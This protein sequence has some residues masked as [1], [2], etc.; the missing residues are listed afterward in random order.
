MKSYINQM[1]QLFEAIDRFKDDELKSACKL[2]FET[3]MM[4][5]F[6]NGELATDLNR[7]YLHKIKLENIKTLIK[8]QYAHKGFWQ[9]LNADWG[10][11][12]CDMHKLQWA[13]SNYNSE[14]QWKK[15]HMD[16]L[17]RCSLCIKEDDNYY[18]MYKLSIGIEGIF[19][20]DLYLPYLLGKDFF[21]KCKKILRL[22]RPKIFFFE[23]EIKY[24]VKNLDLLITT[25]TRE[26]ENLNKILEKNFANN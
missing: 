17:K 7:E 8:S 9:D 18:S 3:K 22:D 11:T 14:E 13:F 15:D 10:I 12:L 20:C 25:S 16:D 19:E 5:H 21:G 1:N 2:A 6:A 26:R 4:N 23:K 24:K